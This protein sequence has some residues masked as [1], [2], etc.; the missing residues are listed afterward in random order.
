MLQQIV[1]L[2]LR[3]LNDLQALFLSESIER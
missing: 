3:F 2:G 1:P